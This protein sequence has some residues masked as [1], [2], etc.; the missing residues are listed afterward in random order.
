MIKPVKKLIIPAAGWGTR[1][2]PLTK[3]V[4]KE[5]V[6]ILNR[7]SLDLLV[8]EALNS[9][10]EEIILIICERKKN[11]INLFQPNQELEI[12]L[13]QKNKI[14]L[15]EEVRLTNRQNKIKFVYQEEQQGLGHALACAKDLIGNE[16][17][18][19]ILGD[20]LIKS[21]IPAIK[22]LID[23][24]NQTG[25]N[26]LGVQSVTDENVHKY[27]IVQPLNI[28]EKDLK[29]FEI[30]GAVEKPTLDSA[31]SNKAILGRYVFNPEILNILS[32]LEY[33]GKNEIQVVDAFA[34]LQNEFQQ[35]I[36]AFEFEGTRYDLGSIDGFVKATIDYALENDEIKASI[37]DYIRAKNL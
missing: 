31:P 29:S 34:K 12:E 5:L 30:K 13:S 4:H 21:S 32:N 33:D 28:G 25:V 18:A 15:L 17:F 2:L 14:K 26:I 1:F 36:Y 10:I 8:D 16:P 9:G 27:G 3:I 11:I 20:D 23:F 24:Y 22:Q 6:P 19:V 35:K 37:S 7:P